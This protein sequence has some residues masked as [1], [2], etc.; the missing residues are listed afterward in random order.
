MKGKEMNE[1]IKCVRKDERKQKLR[2][3]ERQIKNARIA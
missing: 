3:N 2:R 1:E